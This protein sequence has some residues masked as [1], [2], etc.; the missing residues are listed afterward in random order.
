MA[1]SLK[2]LQNQL[3]G[4]QEYKMQ[5]EAALRQQAENVYKPQYEQDLLMLRDNINSNIAQQQRNAVKTGMQRSSYNQAQQA[6]IRGQG[7]RAEGE[8]GAAYQGNVGSALLN[9]MNQEKDRKQAA[10]NQR[11]QLLMAIYEYGRRGSGG[12]AAAQTA[13]AA[14]ALN[15]NGDPYAS[16]N[17]VLNKNTN[18]HV[19]SPGIKQIIKT[20]NAREEATSMNANPSDYSPNSIIA[21]RTKTLASRF[22]K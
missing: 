15:Q 21:N 20:E 11:N 17:S 5:D 16:L 3:S 2:E 1:M 13:P 10:D 19:I 6:M 14:D 4:M 22:K 7:L 8:L 9:L 12:S 18:Y